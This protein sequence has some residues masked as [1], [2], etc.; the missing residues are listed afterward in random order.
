MPLYRNGEGLM[1]EQADYKML[2]MRMK[3]PLDRLERIENVVG[4]G[5]PD[6]NYCIEGMEGWIEIKSPTTPKR[7]GTPLFGSNHK[8][9]QDQKNWFKRQC[10]AEGNGFILICMKS[11]WLLIDGCWADK[12]NDLTVMELIDISTW[13][14][15]TPIY[16]GQWETLRE[17]LLCQKL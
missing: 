8:L 4:V 11:R 10:N 9:S 3:Q 17:A 1:G 16:T 12:V 6:V 7:K 15:N 14:V 5:T 13:H 2:R